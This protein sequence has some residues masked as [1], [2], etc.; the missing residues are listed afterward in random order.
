MAENDMNG[1]WT[2]RVTDVM[3]GVKAEKSFNK[4]GN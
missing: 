3:T 2:L 1:E 4:K